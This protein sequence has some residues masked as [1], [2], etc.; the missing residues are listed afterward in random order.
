MSTPLSKKPKP[1]VVAVPVKSKLFRLLESVMVIDSEV[2]AK[3]APKTQ[4]D[5]MQRL[6]GRG[7]LFVPSFSAFSN[8]RNIREKLLSGEDVS[9]ALE[10]NEIT[11]T[12]D[13]R[14]ALAGVIPV[15]AKIGSI[16]PSYPWLPEHEFSGIKFHPSNISRAEHSISNAAAKAIWMKASRY[17]SGGP[18]P[19]Q[20]QHNS[21]WNA[22]PV[23]YHP[24]EVRIGC[25]TIS[26][27]E[28]EFIARTKDWDPN[29]FEG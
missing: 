17:W 8:K 22:R 2:F 12:D 10:F 27:A 6:D 24:D 16:G 29:I 28:I 21:T 4:T 23:S 3:Q 7:V 9:L 20:H 18:T 19:G 1:A 14:E 13:E 15:L 25:Q 26:R 5:L 11:L